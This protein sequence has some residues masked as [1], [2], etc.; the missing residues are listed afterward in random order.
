MQCGWALA[1]NA[2]APFYE[3]L[4][5][6]LPERAKPVTAAMDLLAKITPVDQL[7]NDYPWGDLGHATVVDVGGG[8]GAVSIALATQFPNLRCI[9]Q[10]L[11]EPVQSGRQALDPALSER[12]R[13]E[14]HSFFD[15]QPVVGADVYFFR[16]IFHDWPEAYG[17]KILRA[18]IPALKTGSRIVINE[19][20]IPERGTV[21]DFA[22]RFQR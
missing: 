14:Q 19:F 18:L 3:E 22:Y 15:E 6:R 20:A 17:I 11:E 2:Q 21:S 16:Y 1:N 13:F 8:R 12:V 9:V 5:R 7:L 10:D 4:N